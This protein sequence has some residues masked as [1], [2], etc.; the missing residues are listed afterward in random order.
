[1]NNN[2]GELKVDGV[3]ERRVLLSLMIRLTEVGKGTNT[4]TYA[5]VIALATNTSTRTV[6]LPTSSPS[7]P[8]PSGFRS[9][10]TLPS[11]NHSQFPPLPLYPNSALKICSACLIWHCPGVYL[12]SRPFL[13]ATFSSFA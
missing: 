9:Q 5:F 8:T 7:I 10:I 4:I 13:Y 1:M 3:I 6:P 11:G 12:F 2:S